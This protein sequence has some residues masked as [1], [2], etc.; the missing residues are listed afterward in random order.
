M[1][2]VGLLAHLLIYAANRNKEAVDAP[3][4][5]D[6]HDRMPK[7][8]QCE[9]CNL[10]YVYFVSVADTDLTDRE[11]EDYL[12]FVQTEVS[13]A[14][15]KLVETYMSTVCAQVPCPKCE[16]YQRDMVEQARSS[17][18]RWMIKWALALIPVSIVF[19]VGAWMTTS[20]H[21]A[22][23]AEGT[24]MPM[25]IFWV[26][27]GLATTMVFALPLVRRFLVLQYD[28]NNE[29]KQYSPLFRKARAVTKADFV[30]FLEER[31][32]SK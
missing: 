16:H 27:F 25:V 20:R 5:L 32:G 28:P 31:S 13:S 8:V 12:E 1:I 26:L 14:G 24:M 22:A 18:S 10:E 15:S 6:S 11:L 7:L 17:R 23:P 3:D 4:R 19:F 9:A 21:L 29:S 2:P 30:R